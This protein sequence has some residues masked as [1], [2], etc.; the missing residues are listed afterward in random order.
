MKRAPSRI[1]PGLLALLAILAITLFS[2]RVVHANATVAAV[3]LLLSVLVT[4]AY[5][6]LPEAVVASCVATL[7]LD[8]FFI[9][10]IGSVT[11]ADPQGWIVLIVFL[12][13]SLIATN[14]S[15][16]LRLQ[17]DE[18]ISKQRPRSCTLSAGRC[19]S[20]KVRNE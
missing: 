9:P 12:A 18:L 3:A 20:A 16:R 15:T 2:Y 14:L 13:V 11:I 8:Y 6:K 5:G 17:R 1:G 4:G 19:C 7:C 10:P